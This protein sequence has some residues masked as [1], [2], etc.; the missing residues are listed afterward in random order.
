[1]RVPLSSV[2]C[3]PDFTPRYNTCKQYVRPA[4]PKSIPS[5]AAVLFLQRHTSHSEK[6]TFQGWTSDNE[7][8][9]NL[10]EKERIPPFGYLILRILNCLMLII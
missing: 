1:M 2:S 8:L 6:A 4:T 3:F 9:K 5:F 10:Q 7:Y